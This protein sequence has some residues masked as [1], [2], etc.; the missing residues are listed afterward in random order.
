MYKRQS[1]ASVLDNIAKGLLMALGCEFAFPQAA[2]GKQTDPTTVVVT[3]TPADSAGKPLTQ[4][5]DVTKCAANADGWYYDVPSNPTK[6]L[7][8]PSTC[9]GP[10]T[11]TKGKLDISV[12]CWAPPPK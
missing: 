8:C 1:Y 4:V 12:G 9:K 7:F 10:G 2:Y 3:Y 6:I 5:T 11:D